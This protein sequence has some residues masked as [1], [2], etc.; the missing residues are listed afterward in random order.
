[1]DAAIR[2]IHRIAEVRSVAPER[3]TDLDKVFSQLRL[4]TELR[5]RIIHYGSFVTMDKGRVTTTA[6]F[7]LTPE[8]VQ[9]HRAS[10]EVL[11]AMTADIERMYNALLYDLNPKRPSL[12]D[13][14]LN[15]PWRFKP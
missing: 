11:D 13:P 15:E 8:R 1:M 6:R 9:E 5:N 10:I 4:I 2:Y 12:S 7:A 14:S 3:R